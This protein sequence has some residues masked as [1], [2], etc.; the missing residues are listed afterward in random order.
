MSHCSLGATG[1]LAGAP[2]GQQC[3]HAT[4]KLVNGGEELSGEF[5]HIM[6]LLN[7]LRV[8]PGRLDKNNTVFGSIEI[9]SLLCQ[10]A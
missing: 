2:L 10:S 4:E 1:A 7:N 3:T 5:T 9:S 8:T 6:H